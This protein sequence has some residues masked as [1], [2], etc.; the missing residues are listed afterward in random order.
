MG[1]KNNNH[2][3]VG[4]RWTLEDVD[5]FVDHLKKEHGLGH[6]RKETPVLLSLEQ[7]VVDGDEKFVSLHF[8]IKIYP[9]KGSY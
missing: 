6:Y 3:E 7:D 2:T 5:N 4:S 9:K 8:R 1:H